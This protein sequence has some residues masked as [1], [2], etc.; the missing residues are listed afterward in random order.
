MIDL[1]E[2]I[3]EKKS[4]FNRLVIIYLFFGLIFIFFLERTYSLQISEFS[5]YE[6]AALE[7]KTKEVLVQPVRGVIYDRN[8][9]I[10]VNNVPSYDLIIKP[11]KILDL[12]K[13]IEKISLVIKLN[14]DEIDF[15]TENFNQ[16]ARYNR[17]LILKKDLTRVE[18][19]RFEVRSFKF[20]N[21]FIDKRYS[22]KN[23]YPHLFSHAIGYVG[24]ISNEQLNSILEDQALDQDET[25][26]SYSNGFLIGKT[27]IENKYD[28]TLR[29]L[30]GKK[31]Y[32]VDAR[33][34]FLKQ[35]NYI[36][37]KNGGSLFTSLDLNSHKVAYDKMNNRRG[38]VVA[39]EIES[40]SIVT[41]L[42]TP[43]FSS[44]DISNGISSKAF[45]ALLKDPNK[46]FFDRAA[47]GRYSPAS[48]IKP[49]IGLYGLEE[50]LIDWNFSINDPGY[51]ILPE[52]QRIYRGWRKGGHGN[53]NLKKAMIVSS[54]TFFFSL[55]YQSNI[56]NLINHL[57]NFGFGKDICLDCFN[58]D[59]GLL[60]T[61][62]WKINNL[63]FGWFKGDT[64][65]LGV[66][67]GYLS[68]TPLQLAYYA[69]VIANKGINKK[70]TLVNNQTVKISE[71]LPLKNIQNSDWEKLHS[72]MIGVI[73]DPQGTAKR[74]KG[75]KTYTVAAKS[76]TVEL[77]STET[78]EDYKI[79]R[80][81]VGN[82]DHAIIIAFGPM[83]EPKYAVSVIIENGESGGSV[84]GPVAIAVLNSLIEE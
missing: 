46:P 21:A 10:I 51:F 1:E 38:A 60:P 81:N 31:I 42:S 76:G 40:G 14:Q 77:V 58:P 44:N 9:A 55:A 82:R 6:I 33:G 28:K 66:G 23:N 43:S 56:D 20:P 75:L 18:I 63:N 25:I 7:N 5:D 35:T 62:D 39:I 83:P 17:E 41:Y 27:G 13:F 79:I 73:D 11:W 3:V 49:A 37:P 53:V 72:S 50:N 52:D 47:Q 64:V 8:G 59:L 26:F 80:E 4:F 32:E 57:S 78:K 54:N 67:Q 30:F 2:R 15:V 74:L 45:N 12:N 68:A 24:G 16:K 19:A 36:E 22:R 65:N 70:L 29:G 84:A 71:N 69:S 61:P 48:T 34:K